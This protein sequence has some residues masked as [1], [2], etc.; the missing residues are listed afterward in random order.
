MVPVVAGPAVCRRQRR[1]LD[2]FRA[3]SRRFAR[4]F[5]QSRD[6]ALHTPICLA[7]ETG[8]R[9]THMDAWFERASAGGTELRAPRPCQ[10]GDG[11]NLSAARPSATTAI[12]TFPPARRSRSPRTSSSRSLR[13]PDPVGMR[14]ASST[15][16][17]DSRPLADRHQRSTVLHDKGQ[18]APV[19]QTRPVCAT[20]CPVRMVSTMDHPGMLRSCVDPAVSIRGLFDFPAPFL[21]AGIRH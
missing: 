20:P 18:H 21:L 14:G 8:P 7:H 13:P 11:V 4:H 10:L 3:R 2:G 1:E 15:T 6:R 12:E 17:A 19:E 16:R 9:R 5:V